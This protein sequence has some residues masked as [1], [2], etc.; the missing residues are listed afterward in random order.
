MLPTLVHSSTVLA[1]SHGPHQTNQLRPIY[2]TPPESHWS[3]VTSALTHLCK[4]LH[5]CSRTSLAPCALLPQIVTCVTQTS[6]HVNLTYINIKHVNATSALLAMPQWKKKQGLFIVV[7]TH[8]AKQCRDWW[9]TC[10]PRNKYTS[11]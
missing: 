3:E 10:S 7:P 2:S 9:P 1:S 11:Q 8:M 5:C 4:I 6:W